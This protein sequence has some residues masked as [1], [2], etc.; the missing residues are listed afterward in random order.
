M[1]YFVKVTRLDSSDYTIK[2][3]VSAEITHHINTIYVIM[4]YFACY[5]MQIKEKIYI[6]LTVLLRCMEIIALLLVPGLIPD[7]HW[8]GDGRCQRLF[9]HPSSYTS[10]TLHLWA[11]HKSPHRKVA[12]KTS[13]I[14]LQR[15]SSKQIVGFH[16]P[17]EDINPIAGSQIFRAQLKKEL[18]WKY[19][20]QIQLR[21]AWWLNCKIAYSQYRSMGRAAQ[22]Y[23]EAW[24]WKLASKHVM[25]P[26]IY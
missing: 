19:S 20:G 1:T 25:E 4:S 21:T 11:Y 18:Q 9:I 5:D 10:N 24:N 7:I 12:L 6:S 22:T 13:H 14:S 26:T 15:L 17:S 2:N 3:T 8:S 23:Q 16:W